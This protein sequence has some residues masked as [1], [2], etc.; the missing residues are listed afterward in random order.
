[1]VKL[2]YEFSFEKFFNPTKSI[3]SWHGVLHLIIIWSKT[4]FKIIIQSSKPVNVRIFITI[5]AD[6]L[7]SINV[8]LPLVRWKL[9]H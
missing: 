5:N 3:A 8:K 4:E 1:M 9:F 7:N 2:F 6:K